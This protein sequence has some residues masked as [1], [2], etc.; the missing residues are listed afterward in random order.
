MWTPAEVDPGHPDHQLQGFHAQTQSDQ[1][2]SPLHSELTGDLD[3][4][5]TGPPNSTPPVSRGG[6]SLL[7]NTLQDEDT[8]TCVLV[9]V[10]GRRLRRC[11]HLK[12]PLASL[13]CLGCPFPSKGLST[14][15]PQGRDDPS[16][17]PRRQGSLLVAPYLCSQLGSA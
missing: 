9:S 6:R 8:S 7:P 17:S 16:G 1:T 4:S 2:W 3:R 12:S 14:L 11:Q 15:S 10:T 5:L 13:T